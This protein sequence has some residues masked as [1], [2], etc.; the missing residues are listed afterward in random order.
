MLPVI[1]VIMFL[2]ITIV[3]FQSLSY[4]VQ[5]GG[6]YVHYTHLQPENSARHSPLGYLSDGTFIPPELEIGPVRH[7]TPSRTHARNAVNTNNS[8]DCRAAQMSDYH[9]YADQ[10]NP[11]PYDWKPFEFKPFWLRRSYLQPSAHNC[12]EYATDDCIGIGASDYQSC[13]DVKQSKCHNI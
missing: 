13:Y 12:S 4:G 11:M 9:V 10:F 6:E 8:V 1:C 7:A 2:L 5:S 3:M